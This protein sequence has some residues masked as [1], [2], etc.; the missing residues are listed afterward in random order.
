MENLL[1]K[2]HAL[3]GATIDDETIAQLLRIA[4]SNAEATHSTPVSFE[5]ICKNEQ[6]H[7][8]DLVIASRAAEIELQSMRRYFSTRASPGIRGKDGLADEELSSD[9]DVETAQCQTPETSSLDKLLL[10]NGLTKV[11]DDEEPLDTEEA[12]K[13]DEIDLGH[14]PVTVVIPYGSNFIPL[15]KIISVV[16]N[17]LV[18]GEGNPID[19]QSSPHA[20]GSIAVEPESMV[21][22]A[23]SDPLQV[24]GMVVD[25]L[26]TVHQ[27]MHLVVVSNKALISKLKES[28]SLIGA[29]MCTLSSH[30]RM[31]EIDNI[32]GYMSIKGSPQIAELED[33]D[34]DGADEEIQPHP[35]QNHYGGRR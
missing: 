12:L 33:Y 6:D 25:T 29:P 31:V 4:S 21:F 3:K 10:K 14:I 8:D 16:D 13:V 22:L 9:S 32:G 2:L 27:P 7:V 24:V 26:G 19:I 5:D 23:G 34:D 11:N 17:L 20:E 28:D 18:I 1:E 35:Q 15:G 30:S